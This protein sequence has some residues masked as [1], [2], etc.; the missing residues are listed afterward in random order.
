ML[1]RT[2][3]QLRIVSAGTGARNALQGQLPSAPKPRFLVPSLH[4]HEVIEL[5][6]GFLPGCEAD[7]A[8]FSSVDRRRYISKTLLLSWLPRILVIL[9]V[10]TMSVDW[11]FSL[12]LPVALAGAWPVVYQIWRKLGYGV[13]GEYGFVRSGFI[14]SV[15]T[16][17]ALYKVQRIDL[18]QT[19]HQRRAGLATLTIHL[20]SHSLTVPYMPVADAARFR[21]LALYYI[22]STQRSWY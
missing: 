9:A 6:A 4:P 21:D 18:R 15:T 22:E 13:V 1:A 5:T 11:T 3:L 8:V 17:F 14:G 10:L 19:P 20:A 7:R 16:V 12:L 2:N